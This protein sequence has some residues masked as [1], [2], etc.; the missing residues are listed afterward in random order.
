M[1]LNENNKPVYL[2][3]NDENM[4]KE[5]LSLY[6]RDN[7]DMQYIGIACITKLDNDL[8]NNYHRRAPGV[9]R[10]DR[11]W[12]KWMRDN[13]PPD[14]YVTYLENAVILQFKDLEDIR[15]TS[16]ALDAAEGKE[17]P[18]HKRVQGA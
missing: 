13:M 10:E 14:L 9:V 16:K 6:N 15:N 5:L 1:K 11:V 7:P 12:M 3:Y 8:K 17:I 2:A 4:P 18:W